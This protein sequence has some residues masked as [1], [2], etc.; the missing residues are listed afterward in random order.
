MAQHESGPV[1]PLLGGCCSVDKP[2][3]DPIFERRSKLVQRAL[4]EEGEAARKERCFIAAIES[5]CVEPEI[6]FDGDP[7]PVCDPRSSDQGFGREVG[8]NFGDEELPF[9]SFPAAFNNERKN[10]RRA[11][12]RQTGKSEMTIPGAGDEIDDGFMKLGVVE[13]TV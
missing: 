1:E 3:I 13:P 10:R 6:A 5:V 2:Q 8:V 12:G 4:S 9:R 7:I 11:I